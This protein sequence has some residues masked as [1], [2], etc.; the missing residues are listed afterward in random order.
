MRQVCRGETV[1]TDTVA[2]FR[3]TLGAILQVNSVHFSGCFSSVQTPVVTEPLP[4]DNHSHLDSRLT[5]LGLTGGWFSLRR[6]H[7]PSGAVTHLG[8][9]ILNTGRRVP[10][11]GRY[12]AISIGVGNHLEHGSEHFWYSSTGREQIFLLLRESI[13]I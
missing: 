4:Q 11:P 6:Y 8:E 5:H 13:K 10:L 2:A 12:L 1:V 7:T 9:V 3:R